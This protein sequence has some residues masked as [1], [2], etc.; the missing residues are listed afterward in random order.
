MFKQDRD[1][2]IAY[3]LIDLFKEENQLENF[4][5]KSMYV[6]VR[7]MTNENTA[8]ITKVVNQFKK[9]YVKIVQEFH[10]RGS[11]THMV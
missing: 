1:K 3:A 2:T 10:K 9:R 8:K 4:T 5:K 11:L 6:L 7:E